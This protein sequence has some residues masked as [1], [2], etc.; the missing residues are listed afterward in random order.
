M[1][2]SPLWVEEFAVWD[3]SANFGA[4]FPAEIQNPHQLGVVCFELGFDAAV[5][6]PDTN[7]NFIFIL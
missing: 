4:V 1:H 6:N 7:F 2:L 3:V 5:A